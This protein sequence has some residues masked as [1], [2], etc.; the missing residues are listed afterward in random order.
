MTIDR[1]GRN[2]TRCRREDRN[3]VSYS[4]MRV[5]ASV[6]NGIPQARGLIV[7]LLSRQGNGRMY[8]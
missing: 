4:E 1:T 7:Q 8:P 6:A 3:L 5:R 2:D